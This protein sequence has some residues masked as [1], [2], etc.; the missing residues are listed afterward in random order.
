M[1]LAANHLTPSD[2][3]LDWLQRELVQ[4]RLSSVSVVLVSSADDS[5]SAP[6]V[7][8]FAPYIVVISAPKLENLI[9]NGTYGSSI[10]LSTSG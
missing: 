5:A 10:A 6:S 8:Y 1:S 9:E 2:T 3:H 4:P 7:P